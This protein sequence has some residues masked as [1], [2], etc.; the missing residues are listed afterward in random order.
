V[1][2][3]ATVLTQPLAITLDRRV[4][5]DLKARQAQFDAAMRV[6][7]L[8]G[9]ETALVARINAVR[10]GADARAASLPDGDSLKAALRDL[11]AKADVLRKEIVATKEGGAIT[12]EERLREHTD[13]LY[14]AI[15]SY[16]GEPASYQITRIAVLEDQQKD[17][18]GR[19]DR[20]ASTE[21]AARNADL[22]GRKLAPI[23]LPPPSND[24][25]GSAGGGSPAALRGF[26]FSLHPVFASQAA[27]EKD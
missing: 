24:D 11:S 22:A 18:A 14:G 10:Q 23:A 3:G 5:F 2:S 7:R 25:D 9:R 17:I 19:F 12:G 15:Q 16:E 4:T 8:F 6:S 1:T 27:A 21:L 20:L 13:Q 26:A